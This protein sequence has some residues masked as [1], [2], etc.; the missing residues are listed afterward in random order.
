QVPAWAAHPNVRDVVYKPVS[1]QQT[2][3]RVVELARAERARLAAENPLALH[4]VIQGGRSAGGQAWAQTTLCFT[5]FKGGPGKSTLALNTWY[6]INY[7]GIAPALLISLD[8][9]DDNAMWLKRP[10][11]PNMSVYLDRP[12]LQGFQ[13]SLQWYDLGGGRRAPLVCALHTH[14]RRERLTQQDADR[15]GDLI[16]QAREQFGVVILDT[17]PTMAVETAIAMRKSTRVVLVMRGN[18]ADVHKI[19]AGIQAFDAP[20]MREELRVPRERLGYV[21]NQVPADTNLG[22]REVEARLRPE[23]QWAPPLLTTLA[24]DP[25]IELHQNAHQIPYQ[26]GCLPEIDQLLEHFFTGFRGP[27]RTGPARPVAQHTP[28]ARR[29]G[30]RPSLPQIR[31]G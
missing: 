15:I 28:P 9:P 12:G 2:I 5:A 23:L 22:P 7:H 1:P 19:A 27:V 20:E 31:V 17:P 14:Q 6:A 21:L 24:Y 3:A 30:W 10:P 13:D 11:T 26:H 4:E 16:M 8:V 25:R 29:R 18:V